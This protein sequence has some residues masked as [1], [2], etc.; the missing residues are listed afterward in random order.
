MKWTESHI[1]DLK[2]KGRIRDYKMNKPRQKEPNGKIVIKY[3]K[4]RSKEK[5]WLEWNIGLWCNEHAVQL[6]EEY[7]FHAERMWRADWAI[8]A[9]RVLIEYEGLMSEKSRHTTLKGFSG[10]TN[11]YREAAKQGWTVLRYTVLNYREVIKDLNDIWEQRKK[12]KTSTPF[13]AMQIFNASSPI[14]VS[15]VRFYEDNETAMEDIKRCAA[16]E[17]KLEA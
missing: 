7:Q 12:K 10:D 2:K 11:K 4:Q 15:P 5:D 9:L 13:A 1:E 3:F 17:Q 16:E 6:Q 8:S 14:P